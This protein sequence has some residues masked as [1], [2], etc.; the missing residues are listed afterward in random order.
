VRHKAEEFSK[1]AGYPWYVIVM[2]PLVL[3]YY[4]WSRRRLSSAL[5]SNSDKNVGAVAARLG[6]QVTEGDPNTNL[7]YFQQPTGDYARQIVAS[8]KPYGRPV[9]LTIIDG[10]KTSDYLVARRVTTKFGCLLE[11][12]TQ[13]NVPPFELYLRQPNQYLVPPIEFADRADLRETLTGVPELDA[14]FIVRSADPRVAVA[15]VPALKVLSTSLVVHLAGE[16]NR[17]WM[18][19]SRFGLPYLGSGP[20]ELLLALESAGCGLEGRAAPAGMGAAL[21]S[22]QAAVSA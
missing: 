20:E 19:F 2:V 3:G 6:L 13:V 11:A 17:I 18:S 10:Q 9:S 1:M 4:L 16:G 22:P 8:G 5:A 21:P 14:L 15:L 7:L 12:A